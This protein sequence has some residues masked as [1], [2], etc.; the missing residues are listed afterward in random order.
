MGWFV[1]IKKIWN[2]VQKKPASDRRETQAFSSEEVM[3]KTLF[4][5]CQHSAQQ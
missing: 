3:K 2:G 5:L 1:S 4:P